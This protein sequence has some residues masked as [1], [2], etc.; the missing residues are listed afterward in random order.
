ML[1]TPDLS[2]FGRSDQLHAA[3]FGITTFVKA[4]GKYPE[5]GDVAQCLEL[6]N[7]H[8]KTLQG[9]SESNLNLEIEEDVFKKAVSYAGCSISPMAAFFGGIIA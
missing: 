7:A 9:E 6:A 4:N 5:S 1:E 2:K 8:M 3:L